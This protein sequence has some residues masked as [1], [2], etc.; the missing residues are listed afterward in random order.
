MRQ[1]FDKLTR[2]HIIRMRSEG[3]ATTLGNQANETV[4][5]WIRL[6]PSNSD[7]ILS[8][9]FSDHLTFLETLYF[10]IPFFV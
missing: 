5:Q 10:H 6:Q 4:D 3:E 9:L 2:L 7:I 8:L 1:N